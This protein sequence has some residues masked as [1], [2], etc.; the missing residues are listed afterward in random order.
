MKW[1]IEDLGRNNDMPDMIQAIKEAGI[2]CLVIGP[3]NKF[4]DNIKL[5][6]NDK[7]VF[8]GSIQTGYHLKQLYP[9]CLPL[10]WYSPNN[11]LCSKYYNHFYDLLF[12]DEHSFI[13]LA[14][15]KHNKWHFYK[16]YSKEA[17]IYVRPD[18]G[19]KIF[20]GQL[21][22]LKDFDRLF[23]VYKSYG[24]K[25]EDLIVVSSPK[26]IKGEWRFVC[27]DQK[28]IIACSSYLYDGL[29]TY[30]GG[31]PLEA[32]EKCKEVLARKYFPDKFFTV[33]ICLGADGNYYLLELNSFNSAGLYACNKKAIVERIKKEL[34]D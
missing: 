23:D 15:L 8:N 13:S 18:S 26:N 7:V 17:L 34:N 1:I 19:E 24:L 10:I 20:T 3:K 16:L 25:E 29:Q 32:T 28:E 14:G 30:V 27:S 11:Y 31:A 6:R 9:M 22:D 4:D 21:L 5:N 33:D 12:N 2:E